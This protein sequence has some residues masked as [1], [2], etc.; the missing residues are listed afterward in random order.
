MLDDIRDVVNPEPDDE[1]DD[2][3]D[4]DEDDEGLDEADEGDADEVEEEDED[5]VEEV[6]EA[7]EGEEEEEADESNGGHFGG[8]EVL[9]FLRRGVEAFGYVHPR[10]MQREV[11]EVGGDAASSLK[12]W[13]GRWW[14]GPVG[15]GRRVLASG[16]GFK[17]FGYVH[18]RRSQ[19]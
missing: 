11:D 15:G 6:D 17:A 5:E 4:S 18:S 16:L 9:E 3:W 12:G 1:E 2:L 13:G 10:R 14:G 19:V 7:D 8:P